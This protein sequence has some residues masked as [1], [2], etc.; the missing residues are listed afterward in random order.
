MASLAKFQTL[1]EAFLYCRDMDASLAERLEAFSLATRYLLPGYQEAVDSMAARLKLA[2]RAAPKIG[3]RMPRFVLPDE[4]GKLL[5]LE[6]LLEKGPVAVVFHRRHWCS[7]CRI[8]TKALAEVQE[9]IVGEGGQLTAITPE[10]QWFAAELKRGSD[11]KFPVLTDIDNGYALYLNLAIWV[12][13]E[14][15]QILAAADLHLPTYQG[16]EAW[17]LPIPATFVV[18]KDGHVVARFVDPDYR[19]RMAIEDLLAA[20]KSAQSEDVRNETP[21]TTP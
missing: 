2:G 21:R 12:G 17:L 4:N 9:Q 11:A 5:S 8:N 14:I 3:D 13:Q 10:R 6:Q 19:K 18:D 15:K 16:N 20:L 7:Y 1:E